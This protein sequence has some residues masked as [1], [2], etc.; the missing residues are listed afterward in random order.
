MAETTVE[1]I[2]GEQYRAG[3]EV[4]AQAFRMVQL[5]P[6]DALRHELDRVETLSPIFEPTAWHW[7]GGREN[8][9]DQRDILSAAIGVQRAL[10]RVKARLDERLTRKAAR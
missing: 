1:P 4:L 7:Q 2:T 10:D 9:E 5:V 6:L 8:L 3:F